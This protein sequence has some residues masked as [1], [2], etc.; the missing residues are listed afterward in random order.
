MAFGRWTLTSKRV[1][2]EKI[3]LEKQSQFITKCAQKRVHD[4]LS[5]LPQTHSCAHI[6]SHDGLPFFFAAE[7]TNVEVLRGPRPRGC[8]GF[9]SRTM[10]WLFI[11]F[12]CLTSRDGVVDV[13]CGDLLQAAFAV[14]FI[15]VLGFGVSCLA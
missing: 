4:F 11:S 6:I 5:L 12:S 10:L 13:I 7:Q 3:T 14:N 1:L 2:T 9:R 8:L 15:R